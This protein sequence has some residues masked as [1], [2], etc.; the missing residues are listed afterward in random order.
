MF[1]QL[2]MASSSDCEDRGK[3]RV[4]YATV[5]IGPS[6]GGEGDV[7]VAP[8]VNSHKRKSSDQRSGAKSEQRVRGNGNLVD[9]MAS[10][11]DGLDLACEM[12]RQRVEKAEQ[13]KTAVITSIAR[14][15][16]ESPT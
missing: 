4:S 6:S 2:S 12:K 16:R 15:P 13:A 11:L 7:G 1:S 3:G 14:D 8:R 9:R 10:K 5:V